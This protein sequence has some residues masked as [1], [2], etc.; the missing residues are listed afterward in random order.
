MEK[1]LEY[2]WPL[3]YSTLVFMMETRYAHT[4]TF[5]IYYFI[6]ALSV[7]NHLFVQVKVEDVQ[8]FKLASQV[9]S[10]II[11]SFGHTNLFPRY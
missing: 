1:Q 6:T 10:S 11:A 2:Q 5:I 3:L 9:V 8:R 4:N 7:K